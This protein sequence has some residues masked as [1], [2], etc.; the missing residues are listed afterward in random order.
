MKGPDDLFRHLYANADE[1]SRRAM[2]KSYSESQG[3]TLSMDWK[4]IAKKRGVADYA[5][6][7]DKLRSKGA[8]DDEDDDGEVRGDRGRSERKRALLPDPAPAH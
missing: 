2:N 7:D 4:A 3:T 5:L 1:A 8:V 6:D